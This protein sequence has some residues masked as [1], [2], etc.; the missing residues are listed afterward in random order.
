MASRAEINENLPETLPADFGDWDGS[1]SPAAPSENK[2]LETPAIAPAEAKFNRASAPETSRVFEPAG[3]VTPFPELEASPVVSRGF[4]SPAVRVPKKPAASPS[5]AAAPSTKNDPSFVRRVKSV[6][7]VVD[8]LPNADSRIDDISAPTVALIDRKPDVPIFSKAKMEAEELEE[9]SGPRLLNKMLEEEEERA[10]RRKWIISASV[11]GGSLILV[12][13]QLFHYG[14]SGKLKNL[15]SATQAATISDTDTATDTYMET[16]PSAAHAFELKDSNGE[17]V[18]NPDGSADVEA[19]PVANQRQVM[20]AQLTAPTRLP[21]DVRSVATTSDA[22]PPATLGGAS[23]AALNGGSSF[24]NVFS[25]QSN[26]KVSGPRT[27]T[28]SSGV[29]SGMLIH[30]TQPIYPSIAKSAR[31]Q[32]TVVLQAKI[33]RSGSVTDLQVV[34]GP[35][36]LRQAAIDAVKTWQYKPY[37]LNNQPTEVNTTIE[38]HF[39]LGG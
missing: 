14:G 3:D 1:E 4:P 29:A 8:K 11:F 30:K 15:I 27:V 20:Q 19:A 31:V 24:G 38:V 36:M 6:D 28:V 18:R 21:A 37:L 32:G 22:P 23:M 13:F 2:A 9:D 5:K 10:A 16:K 7:N 17:A 35:P 25:D 39:T 12:A 33:S 34:G 26:A